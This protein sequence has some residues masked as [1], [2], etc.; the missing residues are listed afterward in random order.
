MGLRKSSA[1]PKTGPPPPVEDE[2]SPTVRMRNL[3]YTHA[4]AEVRHIKKKEDKHAILRRIQIW[5]RP[6]TPY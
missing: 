4:T 3:G 1:K 2:D 6:T 5:P